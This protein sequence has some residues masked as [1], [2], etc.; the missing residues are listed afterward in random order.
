[1]ERKDGTGAALQPGPTARQ[2]VLPDD[3][4]STH[5]GAIDAADDATASPCERGFLGSN[6]RL[7]WQPMAVSIWHAKLR[8]ISA[9]GTP[10]CSAE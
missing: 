10:H 7:L 8:I 5:Q 2:R 4:D 3:R 1:V 6:E 9:R